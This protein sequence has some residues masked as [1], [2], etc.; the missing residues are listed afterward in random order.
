MGTRFVY[1]KPRSGKLSRLDDR[2]FRWNQW[3]RWS[4]LGFVAILL[5]P[6]W[7]Y[8]SYMGI[9]AL[10]LVGLIGSVV[11]GQRT[12]ATPHTSTIVVV[13]SGSRA[14]AMA[15]ALGMEPLH[16]LNSSIFS[17]NHFPI[18][19][20]QVFHARTWN[21]AQ[22]IIPRI[23]CDK[24]ILLDAGD[25]DGNLPMDSRGQSPL[26]V[27]SHV[28]LERVLGRVPLELLNMTKGHGIRPNGAG[29]AAAKRA[30]DLAIALPLGLLVAALLPILAIAIPLDSR[31]PIFYTQTRV[32]VGGRLFRIYKFRSMRQD[33]ET[34]GP[35]WATA[36]D[37]RITRV[38]KF[39]RSTRIDELPQ[40]WNIIRGD[41][42]LIGPRPE[43]PEL[44]TIIEQQFPEFSLRTRVKPG[45][46]GWAQICAGYGRSIHD[47]RTKLEYDLF[48]VTHHSLM[49]DMRILLHTVPVVIG[50][51]GS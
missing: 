2:A 8:A 4:W 6:A 14:L 51:K 46:T 35:T 32:G 10:V 48:Y 44:A 9:G 50:R 30:I 36:N 18:T 38:G 15:A 11:A 22:E 26:V 31:G 1:A 12:A 23:E 7:V 13:G 49:F 3:R 47:S 25:V 24:V 39:L 16:V 21:Q 34:N 37:N 29:Q 27:D 33:A 20:P 45:L 41:M 40:I 43:R 5:L 17:R 19:P 28:D 42:S